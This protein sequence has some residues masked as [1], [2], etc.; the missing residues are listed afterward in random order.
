M[1]KLNWRQKRKVKDYRGYLSLVETPLERLRGWEPHTFTFLLSELLRQ[2]CLYICLLNYLYPC[3]FLFFK[4]TY[5]PQFKAYKIKLLMTLSPKRHLQ[6]IYSKF[7]QIKWLCGISWKFL[8]AAVLHLLRE[9]VPQKAMVK[10]PKKGP[11]GGS[12]LVVEQP[13]L[14]ICWYSNRVHS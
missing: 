13:N 12:Y 9:P 7:W 5:N 3:L 10:T 14:L 6:F 2:P 4:G 8:R 1:A 11:M